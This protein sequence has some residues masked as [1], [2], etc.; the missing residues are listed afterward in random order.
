MKCMGFS[1]HAILTAFLLDVN[2]WLAS[3]GPQAVDRFL[4]GSC[5][6]LVRQDTL[7]SIMPM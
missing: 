2:Q 5:K 7:M 3:C 4:N 6:S 1:E